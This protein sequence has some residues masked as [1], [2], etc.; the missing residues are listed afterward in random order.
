MVS[1]VPIAYASA[2]MISALDAQLVRC[3]PLTK[4]EHKD[5]M[6]RTTKHKVTRAKDQKS[7][8]QKFEMEGEATM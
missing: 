5:A 4:Y 7:K 1:S 8:N 6:R 3:H 2:L